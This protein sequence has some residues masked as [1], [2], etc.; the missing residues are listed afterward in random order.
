MTFSGY[1]E[2][3][4]EVF[5]IFYEKFRTEATC[6]RIFVA[7]PRLSIYALS[8]PDYIECDLGSV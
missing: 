1:L 4:P 5:I 8:I 2:V 6:F 7:R 3:K